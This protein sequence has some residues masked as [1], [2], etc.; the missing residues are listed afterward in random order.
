MLLSGLEGRLLSLSPFGHKNLLGL[1]LDRHLGHV[2]Y[3]EPHKLKCPLG[4]PSRGESIPDNF[5]DPK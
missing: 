3:V 4:D 2:G 1:G 5:F